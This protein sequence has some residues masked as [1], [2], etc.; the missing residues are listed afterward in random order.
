MA[1][2]RGRYGIPSRCGSLS[3][4]TYLPRI[5]SPAETSFL[6]AFLPD[7]EQF[8]GIFFLYFCRLF[9]HTKKL[10][11]EKIYHR[12]LFSIYILWRTNVVTHILKFF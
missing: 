9:Q 7:L 4:N 10:E 2:A 6:R 1:G 11:N 3:A 8:Y 12:D 5:S